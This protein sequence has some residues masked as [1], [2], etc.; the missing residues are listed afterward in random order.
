MGSQTNHY[1]S[2]EATSPVGHLLIWGQTANFLNLDVLKEVH[3]GLLLLVKHHVKLRIDADMFGSLS[4]TQHGK[5]YRPTF[6]VTDYAYGF[7]NIQ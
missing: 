4:D 2:L 1:G 3:V 5:M 7:S 6:S